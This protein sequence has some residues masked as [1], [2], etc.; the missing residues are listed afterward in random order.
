LAALD[1][2]TIPAGGFSF[3]AYSA[4]APRTLVARPSPL[5]RF[6]PVDDAALAAPPAEDWLTW[7]RAYDAH[8]FSPL[9]EITAV[10][11]SQ[12]RLA[13]SWTLPAGSAES[14]PLVRDGTLFVI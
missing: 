13:W 8:G 11:V 5:D 10:N 3:M 14:V 7:R 2:M 12:L 9:D 1:A 6:E 4:Y